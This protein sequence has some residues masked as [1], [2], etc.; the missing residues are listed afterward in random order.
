VADSS[1][2]AFH[3]ASVPEPGSRQRTVLIVEDNEDNRIIYATFL[4]Y[5]GYRVLEAVDGAEGVNMTRTE[6]PDIV[7]M[8][9]SLPTTDGW[10]ATQAIKADPLTA[11]IPVVALTAHALSADRARAFEVGCDG[12]L[13]K[14]VEPKVVVSEIERVLAG[15]SAAA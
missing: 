1:I 4:E 5:S 8:D 7:L 6:C 13:A 11:K 10:A 9:V 3:G 15:R 14:P 12:Y 2:D